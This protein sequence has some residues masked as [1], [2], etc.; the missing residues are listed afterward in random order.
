MKVVLRAITDDTRMLLSDTD[1]NPSG[2]ADAMAASGQ[3]SDTVAFTNHVKAVSGWS[4]F[5]IH[6]FGIPMYLLG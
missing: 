4:K 2:W 6:K 3:A 1:I 5:P